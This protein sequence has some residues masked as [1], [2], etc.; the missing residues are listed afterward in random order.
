MGKGAAG[1]PPAADA[2]KE[3]AAKAADALADSLGTV[4]VADADKA[5]A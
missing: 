2:A 4:K 3:D 5:A 1:E